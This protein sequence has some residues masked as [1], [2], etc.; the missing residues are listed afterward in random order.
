[1]RAR[2]HTGA[3]GSRPRP[4]CV[5]GPPGV[6]RFVST[7]QPRVEPG[8][9]PRR[10]QNFRPGEEDDGSSGKPNVPEGRMG[11]QAP[12]GKPRR[13]GALPAAGDRGVSRR[14]PPLC[15]WGRHRP[16]T[17]AGS[18]PLPTRVWGLPDPL[19]PYHGGFSNSLP[20]VRTLGSE[21]PGHLSGRG[22]WGSV[23]GPGPWGIR[24]GQY[25]PTA[26]LWD[27][28]FRREP[29]RGAEGDGG[30]GWR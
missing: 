16:V 13:G 4:G 15:P 29:G 26:T 30:D 1:M 19:G 11:L 20:R 21:R 17:E 18:A 7:Q 10:G 2:P 25:H 12:G 9:E 6:P 28:G 14:R 8:H 22:P 3:A 23:P 24:V 5:P 27:W